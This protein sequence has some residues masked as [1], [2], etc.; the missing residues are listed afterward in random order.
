MNVSTEVNNTITVARL[1]GRLDAAAVR[2][3]RDELKKTTEGL[4]KWMILNMENVDFID[5]S[6]LGLIVSL[7]RNARENNADVAISNLSAQAQTLF[8]LTRMTRIFS[9]YADEN[10]ALE[11]LS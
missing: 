6:G 11:S 8:E 3:Y 1:D 10:S 5:S 4:D 9:I 2:N 7:V